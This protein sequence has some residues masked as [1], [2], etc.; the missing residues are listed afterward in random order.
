MSGNGCSQGTSRL[1]TSGVCG[2]S[3]A[4]PSPLGNGSPGPPFQSG[5]AGVGGDPVQPGPQRR[6]RRVVLISGSPDPQQRVL[7]QVLLAQ[8]LQAGGHGEGVPVGESPAAADHRAQAQR[9]LVLVL[10]VVLGG[11]TARSFHYR[12]FTDPRSRAIHPEDE[13]ATQS[14]V[15]AANLH[16]SWT[17]DGKDSGRGNRRHPAGAEPGVRRTEAAHPVAGPC[18]APVRIQHPE[19]GPLDLH[20]QTLVDPDQSQ[21]MLVYTATPGSESYEKLKLLSVL[22]PTRLAGI[23]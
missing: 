2:S 9:R 1:A 21:A 11:C 12:W 23:D 4:G 6:P 19:L 20:C 22:G 8:T 14:R 16:G 13:H 3:P 5:E 18:C 15:I 17:R 7:D 10:I